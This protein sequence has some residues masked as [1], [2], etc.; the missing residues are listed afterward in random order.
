MNQKLKNKKSLELKAKSF[1]QA[2]MQLGFRTKEKSINL[3][4]KKVQLKKA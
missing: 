4:L 2:I 1:D 3:A